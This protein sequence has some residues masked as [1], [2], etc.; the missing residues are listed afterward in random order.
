MLDAMAK[1]PASLKSAPFTL[2]EARAAGVSYQELRSG[3]W[4]RLA[5]KLYSAS[6]LRE[7][8]RKLLAAW[9]RSLPE[10]AVFAGMT[11]GWLH[12]LDLKPT[13][14]VEI[15]IPNQRVIR[16]AGL[17]VRR[18]EL[19]FGDAATING[20][21]ATSLHR[22]LRDMCLRRDPVE[23]LIAID[24]AVRMQLTDRLRLQR[25]IESAKRSHGVRR[26]RQMAELAAPAESPMETRLR[27]LLINAGLPRP[28]VQTDLHDADGNFVGRADLYYPDERLVIEFDG[29][30]HRERLVTDDR[31]QNL[32]VDAGYRVLRFTAANLHQRP[33]I[34]EAQ[35]RGALLSRAGSARTGCRTTP[36]GRAR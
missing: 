26:L 24:M 34:I 11:A 3:A 13:D 2:E 28:E 14:P 5:W 15:V 7:D 10:E 6:S 32:L 1:A 4:Q 25:Y 12:G 35:V 16:R 33:D 18:S 17:K 27:W 23:A 9:Q 31:R 29:A 21:R 36:A 20:F 19:K 8:L 22:T 30:N